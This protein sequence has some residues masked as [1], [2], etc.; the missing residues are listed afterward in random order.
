MS[1]GLENDGKWMFTGEE[2]RVRTRRIRTKGGQ[3]Q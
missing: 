1:G 2:K 3:I